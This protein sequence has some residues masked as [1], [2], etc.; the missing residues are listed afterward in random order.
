ME[1]EDLFSGLNGNQV[2]AFRLKELLC[3]LRYTLVVKS[4]LDL[5]QNIAPLLS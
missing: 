5:K 4:V 2:H 3:S 1:K